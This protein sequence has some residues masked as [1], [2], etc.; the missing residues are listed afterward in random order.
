MRRA[1][2]GVV[3]PLRNLPADRRGNV[4]GMRM[5]RV[6]GVALLLLV[7]CRAPQPT[8]TPATGHQLARLHQ[9]APGWWSGA[10]PAAD[11]DFAA[12]AALGVTTLISVDGARPEVERAARHGLQY[13]HVPLGYDGIAPRQRLALLKAA[14][15]GS[16]SIFIHCHH[17]QHRGPAALGCILVSTGRLSPEAGLAFL[18]HAGTDPHY[19]GLHA[20]VRTATPADPAILATTPLPPP[21]APVPPLAEA[22]VAVDVH[23]LRL[24]QMKE[25]GWRTPAGQPGLVPVQEAL[26]L[27]ELLTELHRLG[28]A[29][30]PMTAAMGVSATAARALEDALRAGDDIAADAAWMPLRQSCKD[31]HVAHRD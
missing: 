31:C 13:Y 19:A 14:E 4:P 15:R 20:A 12:I 21:I 8:G 9:P 2:R 18:Q 5:V 17:G 22:M 23:Y 28:P 10:Q 6:V 26:L 25:L 3:D 7:G 30:E 24:G 1:E 11:A 27:R 16:G 29:L